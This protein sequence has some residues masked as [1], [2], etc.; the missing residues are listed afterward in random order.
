MA[1]NDRNVE[2]EP[3]E[4]QTLATDAR[5]KL[6]MKSMVSK[7]AFPRRVSVVTRG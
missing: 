7:P 3:N 1:P 2:T 5:D 4:H 6:K